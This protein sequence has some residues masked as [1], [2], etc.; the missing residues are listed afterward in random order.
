MVAVADVRRWDP[1]GVEA[2]FT[3]FGTARDR[4]LHLD[5]ELAGSRPPAGWLGPAADAARAEQERLAERLRRV[6]AGVAAVR[7]T[8]AEAADAVAGIRRDLA[9]ADAFAAGNG[10]AI[11]A[12]GSVRDVRRTVLPSDR[13]E[14][15][16]RQR[17]AVA[18]R[19]VDRLERV[20][21]RAGGVDA[22]LADVLRRPPRSGST[23]APGPPWSAPRPPGRSPSRSTCPHRR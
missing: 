22:A 17:T 11:G 13:V 19:I 18:T 6:A 8:V 20:L 21:R 4:L 5:F 15:Y 1:A 2:A 12:D 3:G 10:F 16:Q 7:P 14:E 9:D 23:T